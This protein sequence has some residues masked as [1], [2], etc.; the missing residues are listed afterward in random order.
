M[1]LEQTLHIKPPNNNIG[2]YKNLGYIPDEHG[3]IDVDVHDLQPKS[4]RKVKCKCDY[5]GEIIDVVYANYK[6]SIKKVVPKTAC[7]KCIPQKRAECNLINYGHENPSQFPG[8]LEA[9]QKTNLER[10]GKPYYMQTEEY[11]KRYVNTVQKKYGCD[12]VSQVKEIR[13]KVV[14]TFFKNNSIKSSRQQRYICNLYNGIL[15]YPIGIYSAD[16]LINNNII[17]EYNGGGHSLDVK[18]GNITEEERK[19][20]D[21]RRYYALK[22]QGYKMITIVSNKDYIPNDDILLYMK[23]IGVEL[24]KQEDCHWVEFNIDEN[25]M[26]HS[27][28]H[29]GASFNFGKL[30]RIYKEEI[31]C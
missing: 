1:L 16:I 9:I 23:D 21:L 13:E 3:Y 20:K 28:N 5:C 7:K 4:T 26:R 14:N 30:K 31:A 29:D 24:L 19:N 8:Y 15:N 2:Y 11:K 22:K 17:V 10:Y 25:K 12:N 18:V 27:L 6:T